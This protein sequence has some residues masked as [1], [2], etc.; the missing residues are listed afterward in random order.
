MAVIVDDY[1]V[2]RCPVSRRTRQRIIATIERTYRDYSDMPIK[3]TGWRWFGR[4]NEWG[5][6]GTVE[7]Q[8][9]TSGAGALFGFTRN[10]DASCYM[11]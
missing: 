4:E 5:D 1:N 10:G 2:T 3:I 6:V 9:N 7:V 11:D 8:Y